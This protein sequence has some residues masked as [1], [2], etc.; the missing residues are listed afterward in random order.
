MQS[1]HRAFLASHCLSG[2][3]CRESGEEPKRDCV[4][5]VIGERCESAAHG[6]DPLPGRDDL[7]G[8]RSVVRALDRVG[9]IGV[10]PIRPDEVDHRVPGQPEEPAPE[11]NAPRLVSRKRLQ[12]LDEDGLRQVLRVTRASD[13]AGDVAVDRLAVVVEEMAERL[14]VAVPGLLYEPLDRGIVEGH[15]ERGPRLL[16]LEALR[17]RYVEP[18]GTTSERE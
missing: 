8:T 10:L 15:N 12:G 3:A 14:R 2:L 7:V 1:P 5:L 11:G 4:A 16:G 6:F 18:L 17:Q 9:D 13:A